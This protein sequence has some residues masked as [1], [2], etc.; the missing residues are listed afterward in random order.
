[1]S[2]L[3]VNIGN[4]SENGEVTSPENVPIHLEET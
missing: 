3:P 2:C 4:K 1:M